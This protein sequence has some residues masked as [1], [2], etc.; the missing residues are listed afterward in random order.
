MT[1]RIAIA[2]GLGWMSL[3]CTGWRGQTT[4]PDASSTVEPERSR[5]RNAEDRSDA[6]V[7]R[8]AP[9]VAG[10]ASTC[11]RDALAECLGGVW[12]F[13]DCA[14]GTCRTEGTT[15]ACTAP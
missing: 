4:S 1:H 11:A 5:T 8:G 7:V 13:T 14:R 3:A 6:S 9:C 10:A 2:A 12:V 15:S